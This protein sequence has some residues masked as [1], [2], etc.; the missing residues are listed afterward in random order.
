M[1]NLQSMSKTFFKSICQIIIVVIFLFCS[2][3]SFAQEVPVL[4]LAKSVGGTASTST[5]VRDM[6]RDAAGNLYTVGD[7][8]NTVDFDPGA[9]VANLTS[10]GGYDIFITKYDA[11]GDYV[12]AKSLGG[13]Q[14]NFGYGI[15]VDASGNVYTT[16][17]YDGT[18]DFD[19]GVGTFNLSANNGSG[20]YDVFISKLDANGNFVWAKSMGGSGS[21]EGMGIQLDALGNVYIAGSYA[22][23][24]DFDP[25]AGT[26][27]LTSPDFDAIFIAKY[28]SNGNLVWAKSID[29]KYN[30]E[31]Y[32]L[33]LDAAGNVYTTGR[34]YGTPADNVD[35]DPGPGVFNLAPDQNAFFVSKLDANGN[36]VWA[37]LIEGD[38]GQDIAFDASSNV[39]VTGKFVGKTDFDPNAGVFNLTSAA[40]PGDIYVLKLTSSGDFVWVKQMGGTGF[41]TFSGNENRGYGITI[42]PGGNVLTT[43][44]FAGTGDFDPGSGIFTVTSNSTSYPNAFISKLDTDGN[45]IWATSVGSA[46]TEEYGVSITT[47]AS[48]NIYAA[49]KYAGTCD[50]DPSACVFNLTGATSGYIWKLSLG[51]AIPAPT[52]TSFTPS[53]GPIGSTVVITGTNFSSTPANNLV[54]FFN[55]RT[56]TIT[57][58]TPTSITTTVPASAATG[59]ISVTVNCMIVQSATNFTVGA[60]T[61]PTI[62]SFTPTSGLVGTTVTVTGT[63][64]SSTPANNTVKF[65]GTTATVTASTATS[66][67]TTV[68]AG[69]TTGAITVTVAGNTATSATNFTV[70]VPLP[71]ITSFTPTSGS[72]N[73]SVTITGT[74]FSTTPANNTVKFNGTTS[75]VTASTTTSITTTVPAGA[76]IGKISVTVGGNTATST[77]DFTVTTVSSPTI[78][79]FTP[80]SGPVN[81]TVTIT[82]TNFSTTP[83]SNTV[84]FNGTTA[85][86]TASTATS[87]TTTVPTGATTGKISVT[88]GGN[89]ATSTNDF[90]V[91]TASSPT[92]AS[93]TPTSGPVNTTVIITGTNFSTTPANNTVKF[94]G[95]T[96][97]VT[98]STATSITTTVPSGATTGK[99]SVTVAGNTATS[100]TDFTVTNSGGAVTINAEPL[101]TSIGG[102]ITKNLVPLITTLNGSLDINSITVTVQP[103]SGALASISNGS[104]T[105]D[106][107][108]ISFSGKESITIRA[109]DTNGNCAE[110]AFEIEVGGDVKVYNA[111]SPDGKNPIL[112]L[113]F[114]ETLSPKNQVSIYNR[115]GDEVFSISDY[116]NKTRVFAGLTNGGS[117]LPSG[118]YFYK[119]NLSSTGKTMTGFL[120]LKY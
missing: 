101:G 119:I 65:N 34:L 37:K 91:T 102:T 118:T 66:I 59:K 68:P 96:S 100:A 120:A 35:F 77:N 53:T 5:Y 25:N 19:P 88:V 1:K 3:N 99:I 15:T 29:G 87:I 47:D 13:T 50:F 107:T 32:N 106:Y 42:D 85:V 86:V 112:H 30:Q 28:D 61:L 73:T 41:T 114:I 97:V 74:N 44:V 98:A 70:T 76:T 83:A 7:F 84:K 54:T 38:Y 92:I 33:A 20:Y 4:E 64:F 10:L 24:V 49:G 117:K 63:N 58:S 8:W 69:A 39:Y 9:G 82:G 17:W 2:R 103:P 36:F 110:Q 115:W 55:N 14:Y 80:T 109:C 45:F 67:T 79:S 116:D 40:G 71:T 48:G 6:F 12:W 81:T 31:A 104:L 22:Y 11:N 95:T 26:F 93:F 111:V 89:T 78:T 62:T 21:D 16:G 18:V 57:T 113:Q 75:V 27:N 56:A 60:A 108:N 90:T 23:T 105:V 52:I 72:V 94:N 43:G 46:F 51:T